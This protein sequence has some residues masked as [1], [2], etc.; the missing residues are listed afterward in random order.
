MNPC[1]MLHAVVLAPTIDK[2][3]VQ[4]RTQSL[5]SLVHYSA[6][7]VRQP[8]STTILIYYIH[9]TQFRLSMLSGLT[10]DCKPLWK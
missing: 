8:L 5:E 9:I 10:N 7:C 3:V 6:G 2:V 4:M 1:L